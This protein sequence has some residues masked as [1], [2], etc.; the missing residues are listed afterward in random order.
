MKTIPF[1]GIVA[2]GDEKTFEANIDACSLDPRKVI[3]A[4]IIGVPSFPCL[5][6]NNI[7][8]VG[9]MSVAQDDFNLFRTTI[10]ISMRL[11]MKLKITLS[12]NAAKNRNMTGIYCMITIYSEKVLN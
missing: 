3:I 12:L 8:S 1:Q 7:D 6:N 9:A 2:I 5:S 10:T 4:S 11:Q